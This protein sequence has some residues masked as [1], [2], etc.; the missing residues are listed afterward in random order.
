MSL[1]VNAII[2]D[3]IERGRKRTISKKFLPLNLVVD[4][5]QAG[6]IPS[7]R[8]KKTVKKTRYKVLRE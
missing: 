8:E 3:G 6:I 7:I 4:I 1:Y 5:N 2:Y